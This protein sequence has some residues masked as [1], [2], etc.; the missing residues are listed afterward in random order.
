ME[1]RTQSFAIGQVEWAISMRAG[2]I[3]VFTARDLVQITA[4]GIG[5]TLEAMIIVTAKD[6][7]LGNVDGERT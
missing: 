7:K 4:V 1:L 3:G 5:D 6:F 2:P